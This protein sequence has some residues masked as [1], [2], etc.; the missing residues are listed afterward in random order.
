MALLA[1]HIVHSLFQPTKPTKQFSSFSEQRVS[2]W[3][4]EMYLFEPI[5]KM[6]RANQNNWYSV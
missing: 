2:N 3:E 4:F 6:C 1:T 5:N